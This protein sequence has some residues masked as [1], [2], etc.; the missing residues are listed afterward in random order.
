M[1]SRLK[2]ITAS[3]FA[4]WYWIKIELNKSGTDYYIKPTRVV[5]GYQCASLFWERKF[6]QLI[7]TKVKQCVRNIFRRNQN[8]NMIL[9]AFN[10]RAIW[11]HDDESTRARLHRFAIWNSG[12]R[13]SCW[14]IK[15]RLLGAF[16]FLL[17]MKIAR[18]LYRAQH[19]ETE[20]G[21]LF[22]FYEFFM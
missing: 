15:G 16:I 6:P 5:G 17:F 13:A 8:E 14:N 9:S 21:N 4:L 7:V 1:I 18:E 19:L 22:F 12:T 20:S 11:T 3:Q 2:Y 10:I